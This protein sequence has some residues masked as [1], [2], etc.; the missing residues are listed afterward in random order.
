MITLRVSWDG[1]AILRAKTL[2]TVQ[3][4]IK[5]HQE[6]E[7]KYRRGEIVVETSH[8]WRTDAASRKEKLVTLVESKIISGKFAHQRKAKVNIQQPVTRGA[9]NSAET[10]LREPD[11]SSSEEEYL[12][13]V[14][15][16]RISVVTNSRQEVQLKV[17]SVSMQ[18]LPDSGASVNALSKHKYEQITAQ[19]PVTVQDANV[20][21]FPYSFKKHIS[22]LRKLDTGVEFNSKSA[23]SVPFYVVDGNH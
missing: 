9:I 20:R 4:T 14:N 12:Y 18:T 23:A 3:E 22:L 15:V 8:I 11:G 2:A 6:F 17:N 16:E 5:T 19:G 7:T 10:N 1:R 21:I 13:T